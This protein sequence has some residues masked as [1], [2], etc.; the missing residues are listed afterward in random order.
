MNFGVGAPGRNHSSNAL[1]LAENVQ[2]HKSQLFIG[3]RSDST[4]I[5]KEEIYYIASIATD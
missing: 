5:K 3:L 1:N 2:N 4:A